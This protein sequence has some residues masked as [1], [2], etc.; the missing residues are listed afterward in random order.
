MPMTE[1]LSSS[2]SEGDNEPSDSLK[3]N[4]AYAKRFEHNKKREELH[5]LQEKYGKGDIN[6]ALSSKEDSSTSESE[7]EFGELITPQVDAQFWRT[8]A[9]IRERRPEVYD[10]TFKGFTEDLEVP[11]RE[12]K[13]K[14]AF[15]RNKLMSANVP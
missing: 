1:L 8:L 12:K 10:E 14:V 6:V 15:R 13:E 4:E 5:R 3:I 11:T 9:M 2:D 7:D